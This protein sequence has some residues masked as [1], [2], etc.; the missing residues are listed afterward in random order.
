M[1]ERSPGEPEA[2][3]LVRGSPATCWR[4]RS[5][6]VAWPW[7]SAR[8]DERLDRTVALKILAPG[9]GRRRGVQA[10]VHQGVPGGGRRRR[11]AHHPGLRGGR[12]ER[13]PV[14][15][16]AVRRGAATS[17]PWSLGYGPMPPG[18]AAEIIS[19]VASALDAAHGRGL[20]HRDV[21]PANMLLDGSSGAGRPDHV[22]LC[23]FGL[24]K[25]SLQASGLTGDGDLPRHARL[26][27]S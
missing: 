16:D 1:T 2:S 26:H 17:G 20:V 23:D 21:K 4:S 10:A 8:Y 22:Y 11:S 6:T 14:H 13:R 12:G 15:R 25:G 27:L 24:S 5:A 18:R 3:L 9:A 7:C 19:Q